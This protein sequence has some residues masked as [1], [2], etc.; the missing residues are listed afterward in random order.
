MKKKNGDIA[1]DIIFTDKIRNNK[2]YKFPLYDDCMNFSIESF[3]NIDNV[4]GIHGTDKYYID[5]NIKLDFLK[6]ILVN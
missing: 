3:G 5:K 2:K 1:E 6:K 4:L